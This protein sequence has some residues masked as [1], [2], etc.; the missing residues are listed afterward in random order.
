[1]FRPLLIHQIGSLPVAAFSAA[2]SQSYSAAVSLSGWVAGGLT[3]Y[4][5]VVADAAAQVPESNDSNNVSSGVVIRIDSQTTYGANGS[6]TDH[7]WDVL[8]TNTWADYHT[9][10]DNLNRTLN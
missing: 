8:N 6:H 2:G 3:Y 10:Y 4:V 5:F 7:F 1:M 9:S